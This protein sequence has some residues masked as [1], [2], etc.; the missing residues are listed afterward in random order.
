MQDATHPHALQEPDQVQ[1][2]YQMMMFLSRTQPANTATQLAGQDGFIRL[3]SYTLLTQP[4]GHE[5]LCSQ[6]HFQSTF[7][8]QIHYSLQ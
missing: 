6:P 5:N 4:T 7:I 8:R 3:L 2:Y 1:L